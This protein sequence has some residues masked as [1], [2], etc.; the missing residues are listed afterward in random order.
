MADKKKNTT[1]A[2]AAYGRLGGKKG[3]PA[4][5]SKLTST[6]RKAIA[7]KGGKAKEKKKGM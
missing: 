3:G 5:A 2:A 1:S 6:E 7:A 4:R